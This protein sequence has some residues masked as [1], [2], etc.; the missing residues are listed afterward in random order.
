MINALD[1]AERQLTYAQ[2]LVGTDFTT[3]ALINERLKDIQ[4]MR[5]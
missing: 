4:D 1:S 3:S 5:A 2:N